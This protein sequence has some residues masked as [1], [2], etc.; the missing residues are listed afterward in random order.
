MQLDLFSDF[1]GAGG[2]AVDIASKGPVPPT[3][4]G[5]TPAAADG[6]VAKRPR[7][8]AVRKAPVAPVTLGDALVLYDEAVST[9][10]ARVKIRSA[11]RGVGRVLQ[12][13][14]DQIPADPEALRVLLATASSAS[15]GMKPRQWGEVKSLA[16]RGLRDLGVAIVPVRDET[17]LT[18]E[19]L[20]LHALLDRKLQVGLAKFMRFCSRSGI[21][22]SAV[23]SDTFDDYLDELQSRSLHPNPKAAN[24]QTARF[25]NR[26]AVS[27]PGWPEVVARVVHDERQYALPWETFPK[28]FCE[29]TGAFLEA[30]EFG[31]EFDEDYS[32]TVRPATTKGR[33]ESLRRM[34]SILVLSG[35]PAEEVYG[36][37]VLC[38]IENVRTVLRFFRSRRADHQITDG[39]L[40]QVWLLRTIARFWLKDEAAARAINGLI[41]GRRKAIASRSAGMKPKNRVRLRQFDQHQNFL[42][43]A[44]LPMVTLKRIARKG[45]PSY[46]DAVRVMYALQ[47]A[48]LCYAPVRSK[49]LV[50]V[51]VGPHLIDVG[52]GS[53]RSV[54]IHLTPTMT[55]NR[56]SYDAPLPSQLFPLLDAWC[57]TYRTRICP[58]P[59]KYLFPSVRGELRNRG[60][61]ASQLSKFIKRET[62]LQ[63]NLHLFRHLAA[64]VLLYDNPNNME[65]ARQVLGHKSTRTTESAYA[66]LKT[67][68]AFHTLD[69]TLRELTAK[70][71]QRRQ[72]RRGGSQ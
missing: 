50:E 2:A 19:W 59:S 7:S 48:I 22:P 55:K 27:V 65:G 28:T 32:P 47:I 52:R 60:G 24:R 62:G 25:W 12:R 13:P 57:K 14:L 10:P 36:L 20:A 46:L 71:L 11:F 64:K 16:N 56:R 43:L 9:H 39:D 53:R 30:K 42:A 70:P 1:D 31:D 41:S 61:L 69:A 54:R 68:P 15:G 37:R 34:A 29:E 40:N 35:T 21:A 18:A 63:M 5:P 67:D 3:A 49:N 8:R 51:E 58:T 66:E 44:D 17:P 23:R 45:D 6:K 4:A 33:R 72:R 38:E 26:A